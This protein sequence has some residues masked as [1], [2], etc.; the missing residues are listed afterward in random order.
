VMKKRPVL[1]GAGPSSE[2]EGG[3]LSGVGG[4]SV[5]LP[6]GTTSSGTHIPA[7]TFE[8]S[9]A[10]GA[11]NPLSLAV[12]SR[13][14]IAGGAT[15]RASFAATPTATTL[16]ASSPRIDQRRFTSTFRETTE[17]AHEPQTAGTSLVSYNPIHTSINSN[18]KE[19][20]TS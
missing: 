20:S 16:I 7:R 14:N 5:E 18:S 15:S 10:F 3:G 9:R 13:H 8:G 4:T 2:F 12:S 6:H 11:V 17:G 1:A 19:S